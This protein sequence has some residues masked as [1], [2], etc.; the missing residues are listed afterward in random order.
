MA[1]A[2]A[3][4]FDRGA[5]VASSH[6]VAKTPWG[7]VAGSGVVAG[8]ERAS[9]EFAG[10]RGPGL[11]GVQAELAHLR[12]THVREALVA[13]LVRGCRESR[14]RHPLPRPRRR[15]PCDRVG[16]GAALRTRGKRRRAT[17]RKSCAKA[18]SDFS[19]I[20]TAAPISTLAPRGPQTA[21][22]R[23]SGRRGS[24]WVEDIEV[25]IHERGHHYSVDRV[26]TTME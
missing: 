6:R 12:P 21:R 4:P 19:G 14:A 11:E 1:L 5:L 13:L 24:G 22:S 25:G 20:S 8:F 10:A 17:R 16:V 2:V 3:V 15:P 9:A 7:L 18:S 26:G 23:G